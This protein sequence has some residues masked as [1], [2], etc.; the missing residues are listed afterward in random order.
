MNTDDVQV[1]SQQ[2]SRNEYEKEGQVKKKRRE[3]RGSEALHAETF[4]GCRGEFNE[5]KKGREKGKNR[6]YRRQSYSVEI[7]SRGGRDSGGQ[8]WLRARFLAYQLVRDK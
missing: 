3:W 8:A 2:T 5:R 1:Y 6:D 7:N 4:G